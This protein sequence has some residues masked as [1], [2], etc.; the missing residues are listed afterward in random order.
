MH[1]AK[2]YS[3]LVAHPVAS[4]PHS[5]NRIVILT[6][7]LPCWLWMSEPIWCMDTVNCQDCMIMWRKVGWEWG[8]DCHVVLLHFCSLIWIWSNKLLYDNS[9]ITVQPKPSHLQFLITSSVCSKTGWSE[10]LRTRLLS[11]WFSFG[12]VSPRI[13][14]HGIHC[15]V[16]WCVYNWSV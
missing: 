1:E 9:F 11:D 10:S 3:S 12:E 16:K 5:R 4:F 15:V 7:I 13:N 8:K 14:T 2:L 6:I